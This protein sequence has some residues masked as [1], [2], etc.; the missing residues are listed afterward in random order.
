MKATNIARM[1]DNKLLTATATHE[2]T[3]CSGAVIIDRSKPWLTYGIN[4]INADHVCIAKLNNF[5]EWHSSRKI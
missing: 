2:N 4:P 1:A 3:I 5:H